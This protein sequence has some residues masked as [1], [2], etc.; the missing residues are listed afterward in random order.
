MKHACQ[1]LDASASLVDGET[2]TKVTMNVCMYDTDWSHA[3]SN[4]KGQT[5]SSQEHHR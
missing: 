1:E 4:R 3:K 5:A 2:L